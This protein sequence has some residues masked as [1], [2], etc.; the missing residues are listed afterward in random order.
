MKREFKKIFSVLLVACLLLTLPAGCSSDSS[1]SPDTANK[2]GAAENKGSES[3][4]PNKPITLITPYAA[5]GSTDLG[6][7]LLA[8]EAEKI[9]GVPVTVVNT[10]GAGGWIGWSDLMKADKDG[11]TISHINTPN[12]FSGYL[13]PQQNRKNTIDDFAPIM[14]YVADYGTISINPNETRFTTIEELVEYAKTH[15]VTTT[16][17]GAFGDDHIAAVKMNKALGTKFIP[18]HNKGAGE[19]LTA[20]MG[21]HV[22]V[23]FA[24]VG[25]TKV[26]AEN[27][28]VKPLAVMAE[29]RSPLMPDVPT[30]KETFNVDVT[31]FSARGIA[32]P[33]GTDQ[34]AM[35]VLIDTFK[36]IGQNEE[37]KKQMN[38]QGL[39]YICIT[40]DEYM[41][42]LKKEEA[43]LKELGPMLGW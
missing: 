15:E 42:M 26:P 35:D 40:G 32:A 25:D 6:A 37:L 3:D 33:A 7:R 41:K 13:D 10:P 36:Q 12:I 30:V 11:Y 9:L 43:D 24:N 2:E 8:S 28:Q 27:G 34:A 20:V 38:D 29:E 39:D 19:S 31:S 4:F 21:G 1:G 22:D 14:C 23:M 5:G 16:S 17:T 18:V